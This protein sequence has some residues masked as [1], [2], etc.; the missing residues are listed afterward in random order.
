MDDVV[1]KLFKIILTMLSLMLFVLGI[2]AQNMFRRTTDFDG[3]GKTDYAVARNENGFKV[4]YVWQSTAGFKTFQ[5]G[6]ET[7]QIVPGDYDGDGKTDQ[8]IR[9]SGSPQSYYWVNGSQ[10]GVSI[11]AWGLSTDTVVRY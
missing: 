10:N 11:F 8:A 4:W 1:R 3:D 6:L 5:W 9:R 2:S 7:D